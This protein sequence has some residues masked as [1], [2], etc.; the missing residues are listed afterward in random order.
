MVLGRGKYHN[1]LGG[2]KTYGEMA[3]VIYLERK[4][5]ISKCD[6]QC[7]QTTQAKEAM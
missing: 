3:S 4:L 1:A 2:E 6:Q 5:K 7:G